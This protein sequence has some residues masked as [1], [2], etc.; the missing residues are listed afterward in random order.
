[1]FKTIDYF[2]DC[3]KDLFKIRK[4]GEGKRKKEKVDLDL[5]SIMF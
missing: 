5:I 2:G 1:L 3:A 4:K